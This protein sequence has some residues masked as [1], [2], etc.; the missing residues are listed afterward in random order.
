MCDD[1]FLSRLISGAYTSVPFADLTHL[2]DLFGFRRS[3]VR[4]SHHVYSRSGVRELINLQEETRSPISS[5]SSFA[6]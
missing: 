4:G 1:E 6:W 5:G 3:R 2:V